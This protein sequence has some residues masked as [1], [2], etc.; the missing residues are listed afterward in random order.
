[1]TSM[2]DDLNSL[3]PDGAFMVPTTGGAH[4]AARASTL[5]RLEAPFSSVGA[6]FISALCLEKGTDVRFR[7]VSLTPDGLGAVVNTGEGAMNLFL[8]PIR[9]KA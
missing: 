2:L 4:T 3:F 1:L 8:W 5:V 6:D 7:A 9:K